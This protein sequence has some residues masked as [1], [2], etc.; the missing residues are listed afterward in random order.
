M[1]LYILLIIAILFF[2]LAK[3]TIEKLLAIL[4]LIFVYYYIQNYMQA[5]NEKLLASSNNMKTALVN[6]VA[7]TKELFTDNYYIH[8]TRKNI[9]YLLKNQQ[10]MDIIRNVNFVKK[11]S[12]SK[13]SNLITHI[14]NLVKIY[15]Y[16]LADRYDINTY[17]PIFTD[18]KADTLEIFYSLV[19][20]VPENL[21]GVYSVEPHK[22]IQK[23]IEDF[24]KETNGMIQIIKNYAII[25]KKEPFVNVHKYKPYEKNKELYLP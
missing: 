22:E 25:G 14:N 24:L 4:I 19:F 12:K 8:K 18:L 15:I 21:D 16:M 1:Y 6:D 5:S 7:N 23:S 2:I 20:I 13:Y 3:L 10:M 9:K 17:L 11:F